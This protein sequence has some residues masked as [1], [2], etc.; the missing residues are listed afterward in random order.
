[1][2]KSNTPY[3][4]SVSESISCCAA[5]SINGLVGGDYDYQPVMVSVF[6]QLRAMDLGLVDARHGKVNHR[7]HPYR[8]I[9][10]ESSVRHLESEQYADGLD[11]FL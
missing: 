2:M 3:S 1:M 9:C 11:G 10:S 6:L 5:E 8:R 4:P 7:C